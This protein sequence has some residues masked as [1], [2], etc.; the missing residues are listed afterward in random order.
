MNILALDIGEKRTG[1]AI[2]SSNI[3]AKPLLSIKH[4]DI[5]DLINQLKLVI[6][7]NKIEKIIIGLP[8]SFSRNENDQQKLVQ[9]IGDQ[10]SKNLNILV[11]YF[12]ETL[13][14][15]ISSAKFYDSKAKYD[16]DSESAVLI[17]ENWLE[18]NVELRNQ[19]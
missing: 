6:E 1:L 5:S 16:K 15:K 11:E 8:I 7:E 9:K 13:T 17:L 3:I 10:I 18:N 14:T 2:S 12:D 4:I 19:N